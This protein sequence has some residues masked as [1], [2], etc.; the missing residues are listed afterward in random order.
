[1]LVCT[2]L[3]LVQRYFTWTMVDCGWN[4]LGVGWIDGWQMYK[5]SIHSSNR[6]K[7]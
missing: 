3:V 2:V 4:I 6:L 7:Y 1:M 5:A